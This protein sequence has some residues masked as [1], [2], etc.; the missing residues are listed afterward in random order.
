MVVPRRW[1]PLDARPTPKEG[2]ELRQRDMASAGVSAQGF[3][4]GTR[5]ERGALRMMDAFISR[6]VV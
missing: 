2:R 5:G 4:E 6:A 1:S 3:A